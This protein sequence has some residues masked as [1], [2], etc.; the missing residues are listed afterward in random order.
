MKLEFFK[1]PASDQAQIIRETAAQHGL[2]PVMVEK[3][4]WVS[5][6]LAVLFAHPEFGHQLVFKGG[7]S[8]SKVFSVIKRFSE[9][10]DLSVSPA[11]LGISEESVEQAGS[12]NK[13]AER[14]KELEEACIERVRGRFLPELERIASKTLGNAAGGSAW[15]EF[16]VDATTHSPVVLFHYPCTEPSGFE[17]LRR[18]VKMEFGSLTDQRPAGTYAV[19]P[20]VAEVF[21]K[22][23]EDFRCELMALELERTFWEK[24]TILHSEYYRDRAKPIRDRF[25][26]HY[27]DMAALARHAVAERALARNDLRQRVANWKSRF[28]A[29]SWARYDLAR[30]GTFRLAPPEFRLA[31]LEKDHHAMRDMFLV[32][33]PSFES[34]I[35][36]VSDLEHEINQAQPA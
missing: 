27:S 26:R 36:T 29:A 6:T 25:S 16:Q 3:D 11:F 4:F 8:L 10:I 35:K 13:R 17:Y 20:W 22:V 24:A 9:D 18:F 19:Q 12:R 34:V 2:L 15:M 21:P 1:R 7:T 5:W 28:F 23:F 14:M 33:P 31:E 32:E 30:P